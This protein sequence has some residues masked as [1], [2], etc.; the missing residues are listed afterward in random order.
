MLKNKVQIYS[1]K[2]ALSTQVNIFPITNIFKGSGTTLSSTSFFSF[3]HP[4][5]F[6]NNTQTCA[7]WYCP[8]SGVV[9]HNI[10]FQ[11]EV[12]TTLSSN[13]VLQIFVNDENI[14]E[15]NLVTTVGVQNISLNNMS[16]YLTVGDSV[17]MVIKTT[18]GTYKAFSTTAIFGWL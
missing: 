3:I 12:V 2:A 16:T 14:A 7:F 4:N 18:S 9:L 15:I 10:T 6:D 1:P 8:V 11:Y 5:K 17:V 13:S